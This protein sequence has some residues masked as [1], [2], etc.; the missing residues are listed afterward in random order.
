MKQ[1]TNRRRCPRCGG[2]LFIVREYCSQGILIV[3][4][5]EETCLQCGYVQYIDFSHKKVMEATIK[6]DMTA[7][8]EPALV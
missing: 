8:N 1:V 7:I 2:N 6:K 3:S 4:Y 5:E